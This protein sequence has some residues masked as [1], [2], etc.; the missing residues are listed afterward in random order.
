[1]NDINIC[2]SCDNNYAIYAGV[3]IASILVNANKTDKLNI[4]IFDGGIDRENKKAITSL[5]SIHECS[6]TF[7]QID[8]TL[9][10]D[11]A[12]IKTHNYISLATYYRLKASSLLPLLKRVI[13]FDCDIVVNNSLLGLFETDIKDYAI[14]GVNDINKRAVKRNPKYINAGV[15]LIN[16]DFW[17]HNDVE[18]QLL[19]FTKNNIENIKMGDQEIINQCLAKYI[20]VIN[21]TWNVQSSNFTNRSSYIKEPN[22]VHFVS[23]KKPWHWASYSYHRHLYF[24]YLQLTPWKLNENNYRNWTKYNQIASLMS[25]FIYRPLFFLRPRF[26]KAIYYTYFKR[27]EKRRL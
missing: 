9:F 7:V 15:L 18:E 23:K 19:Q 6:I 2:L 26:Y 22:I 4:Y 5:K 25:Y 27:Y 21:D 20:K 16:L 3:L 17:R 12:K 14:A 10:D 13:Y 1:M 8:N 11:Y 24:K